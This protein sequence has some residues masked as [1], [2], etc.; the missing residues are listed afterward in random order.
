MSNAVFTPAYRSKAD[1]YKKTG[2]AN[3]KITE[4]ITVSGNH[5]SGSTFL[6]T[7]AC[8]ASLEAPSLL[9][10][11]MHASGRIN[12]EILVRDGSRSYQLYCRKSN[13]SISLYVKSTNSS[14]F[15]T[16]NTIFLGGTHK[17]TN[18]VINSLPV[19]AEIV[20]FS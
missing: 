17:P 7:V 13:A 9:A 2:S 15:Y 20:R 18:T 8:V 16:L 10:I 6:L 19:D 14:E 3:G 5:Y 12:V 11:S 1:D 4:V